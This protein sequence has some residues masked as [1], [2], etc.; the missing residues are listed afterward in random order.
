MKLKVRQIIYHLDLGVYY[1]D[2]SYHFSFKRISIK[3]HDRDNVFDDYV[4]YFGVSD[5]N[6][7]SFH[8]PILPESTIYTKIFR[9]ICKYLK[10]NL[11]KY[12][13]HCR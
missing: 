2:V 10:I 6:S 9:Y 7:N 13:W 4:E 11:N 5:L 8:Y 1:T 12:K 3:I